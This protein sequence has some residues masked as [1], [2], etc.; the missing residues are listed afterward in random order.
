MSRSTS[1]TGILM[2]S[3]AYLVLAERAWQ[4][5]AHSSWSAKT[6]AAARSTPPSRWNTMNRSSPE[7]SHI[8]VAAFKQ[9]L[10]HNKIGATAQPPVSPF[11]RLWTTSSHWRTTSL[12]AQGSEL[13]L[14]AATTLAHAAHRPA[15]G[16]RL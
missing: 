3:V 2:L 7:R 11:I 1:S 13:P 4:S 8:V 16:G 12:Q 15:V 9:G 14:T 5:L 6:V 10:D